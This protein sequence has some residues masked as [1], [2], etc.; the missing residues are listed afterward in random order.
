MKYTIYLR[1]LIYGI[2][3][4]TVLSA[5]E[6]MDSNTGE[7]IASFTQLRSQFIEPSKEYGTI[8][9]FVW[10]SK[11]IRQDIG[12]FMLEFSEAGCGGIFIH[13]RPGLITS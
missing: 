7:A 13:A 12:T 9:F 4:L 5:Y 6:D 1:F 11:I 8:P 3:A 2:L 10:N